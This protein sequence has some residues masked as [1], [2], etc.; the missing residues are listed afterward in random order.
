MRNWLFHPIIFYPLAILFS[1]LVIVV[2]LEPQ[3]WPRE[4]AQVAGVQDGEWLV[5]EGQSFNSPDPGAE[6]MTVV[7]DYW[8]R[9][10]TMRIAQ[11]RAQPEPQPEEDG[12]RLLLTPEDGNA[13]SGRPLV[14][15]ISYNPSPVNAAE[16]L[17]VSL[18]SGDGGPSPWT[19]QEA[20]PQTAT[21]RFNLPA[22]SSVN[23]IGVR[24]MSRSDDQAYGIEITRIRI[25]T[26]T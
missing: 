26:R 20:P 18:R 1:A 6:E 23:A 11:P 12:T 3:S 25:L 7:R 15:E 16:R 24:A 21:L 9:A 13:L 22:R 17:A 8:G 4:P 5:F 14:V 10:L 19:S 2:S